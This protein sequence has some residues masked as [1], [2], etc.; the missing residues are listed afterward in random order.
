MQDLGA[1]PVNARPAE[2]RGRPARPHLGLRWIGAS[3]LGFPGGGYLGWLVGGPVDGLIPAMIG[4]VIT[5]AGIGAA[6]W[7]VLRRDLEMDGKWIVATALGLGSGLALGSALVGY[8]T[9]AADLALMGAV[10]GAAVGVAQ[11]LVLRG[12]LEGWRTWMAASPA[13]WAV[14]WFVTWSAGIGVDK[15]F[16]VFGASGA[17]VFGVLSGVL[18]ARSVRSQE[19]GR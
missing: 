19:A 4:G 17:T 3:L 5:G 10:S 1:G 12:R 9:S 8:G 15:Q 16:T 18:L 6:Q 2:G 7:F 13:L 11:G 14:A